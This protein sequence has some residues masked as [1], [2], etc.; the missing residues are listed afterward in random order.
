MER[1]K[2]NSTTHTRKTRLFGGRTKHTLLALS[3]IIFLTCILVIPLASGKI[4]AYALPQTS[5][6]NPS[7]GIALKSNPPQGQSGTDGLSFIGNMTVNGNTTLNGNLAVSNAQQVI[8]GSPLMANGTMNITGDAILL[9]EPTNSGGSIII[10]GNSTWPAVNSANGSLSVGNYNT[11]SRVYFNITDY[12]QYVDCKEGGY[13][14]TTVSGVNA[15]TLL[16]SDAIRVNTGELYIHSEW[17]NTLISSIDIW[18]THDWFNITAVGLYVLPVSAQVNLWGGQGSS[19]NYNGIANVTQINSNG[20]FGLLSLGIGATTR[21]RYME[22]MPG[23]IFDSWGPWFA[24]GSSLTEGGVMVLIDTYIYMNSSSPISYWFLDND[25]GPAITLLNSDH[26]PKAEMD[27]STTNQSITGL[28]NTYITNGGISTSGYSDIKNI[29]QVTNGNFSYTGSMLVNGNQT[30]QGNVTITGYNN[31]QAPVTISGQM[32][33]NSGLMSGAVTL[34]L[35]SG[36]METNGTMNIVNGGMNITSGT[37]NMNSTGIYMYGASNTTIGGNIT[38]TGTMK[39]TGN[40]SL[41]GNIGISGN[42]NMQGNITVNGNL[43]INDQTTGTMILTIAGTM[44]ASSDSSMTI[45]NGAIKVPSGSTMVMNSTGSFITGTTISITGDQINSLGTTTV[46]G[47]TTIQG[48]SFK[49][50]SSTIYGPVS[51]S[52]STL[53]INNGL[54]SGTGTIKVSNGYMQTIGTMTL[55]NGVVT[56]DGEIDMSPTGTTIHSNTSITS[57]QIDVSGTVT[58]AGR[59]TMN[60]NFKLTIPMSITGIMATDGIMSMGGLGTINGVMT[61]TGNTVMSG[62]TMINGGTN[63]MGS[64]I[65]SPAAAVINGGVILTGTLYTSNTPSISSSTILEMNSASLSGIPVPHMSLIVNPLALVALGIMAIGTIFVVAR[66]I[67]IG[68]QDRRMLVQIP[69]V[70]LI[71]LRERFA[72]LRKAFSRSSGGSE[73]EANTESE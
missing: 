64:M 24:V 15:L 62:V 6:T 37:M 70:M 22:I 54:M 45:T 28:G 65:V 19:T 31:L 51:I 53:N 39:I 34:N 69:G 5:S 58:N 7:S 71:M 59:V 25:S 23:T 26:Y 18:I 42:S 61:I 72:R 33:V 11:G 40:P 10:G 16:S 55:T 8:L 46:N 43:N 52:N 1:S 17:P 4:Q 38:S 67:Y 41:Q 32:N 57:D 66:G 9:G 30:I 29:N 12:Y 35:P 13:I 3:A 68:Y 48:D 47:N 50:G 36:S 14:G 49:M 20:D 56:V 63:I 21:T 44:I 73:S 27:I 60:G 2:R